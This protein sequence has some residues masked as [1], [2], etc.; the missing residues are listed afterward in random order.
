M[1][2][3]FARGAL[4]V[5]IQVMESLKPWTPTMS[6][7]QGPGHTSEPGWLDDHLQFI[8]VNL[9]GC[10]VIFTSYLWGLDDMDARHRFDTV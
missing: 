5:V 8:P 9:D 2:L 10:M 3:K 7:I 6:Y 1:T 4:H